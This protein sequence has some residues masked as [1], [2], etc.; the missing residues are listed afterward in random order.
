MRSFV[1]LVLPIALLFS[2]ASRAD[3]YADTMG[4]SR[5]GWTVMFGEPGNIEAWHDDRAHAQTFSDEPCAFVDDLARIPH[6]HKDARGALVCAKSG[7]SPL[8]GTV[9]EIR[10]IRHSDCE[11]GDPASRLTCVS[12][13]S[14]RAPRVLTTGYWEC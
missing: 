12:G 11:R 13:C 7:K 9:Y 3:G 10:P 5:S 14:D 1:L 6:P 4:T 2:P 8:A